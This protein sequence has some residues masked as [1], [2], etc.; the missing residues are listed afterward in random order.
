[1]THRDM[2]GKDSLKLKMPRSGSFA[3]L[4]I[5]PETQDLTG[6]TNKHIFYQYMVDINL[7]PVVL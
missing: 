3:N 7:N 1:M 6:S 2:V 5:I 4:N